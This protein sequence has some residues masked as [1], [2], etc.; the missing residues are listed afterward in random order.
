MGIIKLQY[1]RW[2]CQG[3]ENRSI[4][5]VSINH[6]QSESVNQCMKTERFVIGE[7][8]VTSIF[9]LFTL[10]NYL[11]KIT[12]PHS[13]SFRCLTLFSSR[14]TLRWKCTWKWSLFKL[15]NT[16]PSFRPIDWTR[17]YYRE[18]WEEIYIGYLVLIIS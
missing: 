7:T 8:Y 17:Y 1:L 18:I 10:G 3:D 13:N 14:V 15:F 16:T 4:V 2:K 5:T 11:S 9:K 12:L 6:N